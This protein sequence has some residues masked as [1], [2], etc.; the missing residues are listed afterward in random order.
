MKNKIIAIVLLIALATVA[1]LAYATGGSATGPPAKI[2][3]CHVAGLASDPA[4]Y[5]TL[6]LPPQAVYGNGGHFNENGTPQA[7]HEQDSFGACDPP[8]P[9]TDLC[10]EEGVQTELPCATDPPVEPPVEPPVTPPGHECKPA[11]PDGSP[12]GK[13]GKPG[14][15]DC[16]ADPVDPPA[17]VTPP[18]TTPPAVTAP[19]V[20]S[21]AV[22]PPQAKPVV[23]IK[24]SVKQ[25]KADKPPVK[26]VKVTK[27]KN[28]IVV[29]KT[30][31]GKTHTGVM[32][33]G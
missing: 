10:P 27:K 7:G 31:D 3:I 16:A 32:G 26:I 5:I 2:T 15:D 33:S 20:T 8:E 17:T 4:N 28:G 6:E 11:N 22:T 19:P 30:S 29:I 14:N 23:K 18:V 12:G 13:D 9:P 24:P 1:A 25:P 21:T